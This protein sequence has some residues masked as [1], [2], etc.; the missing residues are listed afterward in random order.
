M[1]TLYMALSI[2]TSVNGYSSCF[3]GEC[4]D[5]APCQSHELSLAEAQ[6]MQ[7]EL[8]KAGAERV[9]DVNRFDPNMSTIYVTYWMPH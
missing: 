6:K 9:I 7:W 2:T 5:G 3:F 4:I 1:K 8:V